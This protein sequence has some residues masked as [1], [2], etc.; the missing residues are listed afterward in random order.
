M[1]RTLS[2]ERRK[3]LFNARD[4]TLI[5]ECPPKFQIDSWGKLRFVSTVFRYLPAIAQLHY[6]LVMVT[7]QDGLGTRYFPEAHFWPIQNHIIDCFKIKG[8]NFT[9]VHIDRS[10]A[11]ENLP[12][13]KPGTAMLT[14]YFEEAIYDLEHSFVIGGRLTDVQLA[15][16]MG[17]KAILINYS[18][19]I[20]ENHE[21]DKALLN[22]VVVLKTK[23]W[24]DVYEFLLMER[25]VRKMDR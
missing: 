7:N 5:K 6:E 15:K 25:R 19:L 20:D 4:G 22:D 16:H 21:F 3:V 9:D 2:V 14:K 10:F 17:C 23:R 12:T 11:Y 24:K 13:R 8:V 18:A 1:Y